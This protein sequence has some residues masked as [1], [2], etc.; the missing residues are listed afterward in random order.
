[1]KKQRKSI[2]YGDRI[3]A[4][5]TRN[6]KTI[7]NFMTE[8]VSNMTEL[9]SELRKAMDGISGLVMLHIRNYHKGWGEERPLMLRLTEISRYSF[10][11]IKTN[12]SGQ[13]ILQGSLF[14][15]DEL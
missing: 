11:E 3:F 13:R 10:Q 6:G 2:V 5:V 12:G 7:L 4:R 15:S 9:L 8:R 1:M 14:C